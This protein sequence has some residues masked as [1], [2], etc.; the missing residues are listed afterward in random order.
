ML[1]RNNLAVI[2]GSL[3]GCMISVAVAELFHGVPVSEIHLITSAQLAS[4]TAGSVVSAGSITGISYFQNSVIE[5]EYR[6]PA[7]SRLLRRD[8][9]TQPAPRLSAPG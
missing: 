1:T 8:G 7:D 6:A 9:L 5:A 4:G 2:S 3:V